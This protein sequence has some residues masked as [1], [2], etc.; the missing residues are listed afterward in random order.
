MTNSN[1]LPVKTRILIVDDHPVTRDGLTMLINREADLVVSSQAETAAQALAA[2]VADPPDLVLGD[3]ALPD[4]SGVELLKNIKAVTPELP[5]LIISMHEES[6]YAERSLRAG[7]SGYIMKS[8]GGLKL[9]EAIRRV[10]AGE[11]YV[12]ERVAARILRAMNGRAHTEPRS[13]VEQ[14]SDR[15]FEVFRLIAQGL[16][17]RAI[18]EQLHISSKTV[19]AH[20]ANIKAKLGLN[21][22][23]ELIAYAAQ[24]MSSESGN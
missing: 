5:V 1:S 20:R 24:W 6:L 2:V 9:M 13:P 10:L 23:T 12:S 8:E 14:L 18:A 17:T 21:T 7:A 16:G 22:A 4:K 19:E 3:I 15:E 11:V